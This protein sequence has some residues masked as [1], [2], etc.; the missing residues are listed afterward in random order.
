MADSNEQ[1]DLEQLIASAGWLRFLEHARQHWSVC[2]PDRLMAAAELPS[3][4][5]EVK[6]VSYTAKQIN[7]LL[8][9]PK[10]RLAHLVRPQETG[11][12]FSRGGYE[13]QAPR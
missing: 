12:R 4:D 8:T 5:L 2:L 7:A 6:K 3:G 13:T 1:A 11:T 10:E 9:Y